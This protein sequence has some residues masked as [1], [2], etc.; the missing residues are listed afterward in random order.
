[1]MCTVAVAWIGDAR[2]LMH[3]YFGDGGICQV[4]IISNIPQSDIS[5]IA[6][7]PHNQATR[8]QY[9]CSLHS[10]M[11]LQAYAD[12]SYQTRMLG[13]SFSHLSV[14]SAKM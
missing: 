11:L 5:Q 6:L 7:L 8:T 1:M 2:G 10:L 14:N 12:H 4:S 13:C 9:T 3:I